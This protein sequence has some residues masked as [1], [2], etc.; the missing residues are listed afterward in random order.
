MS[1]EGFIAV[2]AHFI[3]QDMIMRRL[4]LGC[5][6]YRDNHTAAN[7]REC[8]MDKLREFNVKEEQVAQLATDDAANNMA[9]DPPFDHKRCIDHA[10]Q[11]I[12][13]VVRD[14]A[15]VKG[16][17]QAGRDL[18]THFRHSFNAKRELNK[19]Q[20]DRTG[21]SKAL[22]QDVVT[23]W[24][25]TLDCLARLKE[26]RVDIM[27]WS[28]THGDKCNALKKFNQLDPWSVYGIIIELLEPF[29]RELSKIQENLSGLPRL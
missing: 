12:T 22:V 8:L 17:L 19:I 14:D 5:N 11:N 29:K 20:E 7:L 9:M 2:T 1:T 24:W 21:T 6:P 4:S 13:L 18:V 28:K 25:S 10:L 26:L 23:R 3:D 27:K 16:L 15:V